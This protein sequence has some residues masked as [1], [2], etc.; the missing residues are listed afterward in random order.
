MIKAEIEVLG[1]QFGNAL[2]LF[3]DSMSFSQKQG[4]LCDQALACE[5]AGLAL[6]RAAKKEDVA[7]DY[8]EDAVNLY[9]GYQSLA[10]VNFI[11]GN[12]IPGWDD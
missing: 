4:H 10:K 1:G 7:M 8:L 5:R 11:K 2:E 6:R 12:I 3:S 9:R